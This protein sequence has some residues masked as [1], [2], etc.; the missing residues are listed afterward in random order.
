MFNSSTTEQDILSQPDVWRESLEGLDA[1]RLRSAWG[2]TVTDVVVTGC[3]S[4]HYLALTAAELLRRVPGLNVRAAPASE[5]MA[6]ATPAY[7]TPPS[8][9]LLAISRSG[10]TSETVAAVAEFRRLGGGRVVA[11]TTMADSTLAD[12][13]DASVVVSAAAEVSVAQTRSFSSMLLAVQALFAALSGQDLG[14]L[15]D[16]P[17]LAT[18]TLE[19]TRDAVADVA[20]DQSL[21]SFYFLGSGPLFGIAS[22]A[23]LKLTE[24]SLTQSEAYHTLEFRHGPMS[25]CDP[26]AAVVALITPERLRIEQT[27][28]ND[29]TALGVRMLTLGKAQQIEVPTGLPAWARPVLYLL[30]LQLLALERCV[31]KG[32]NPDQ[33]RHLTA[34]I[35]LDPVIKTA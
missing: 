9:L 35:H 25:M 15:R 12:V 19:R 8:A 26:A 4:T 11:I 34:V 27:V 2:P 33:P 1:G 10:E 5:L 18:Q 3:G 24:M 29:V 14:V 30:P 7:R 21:E 17:E 13:A 22:E 6:E 23:M 32:L 16:L 31:A 20:R 28:V